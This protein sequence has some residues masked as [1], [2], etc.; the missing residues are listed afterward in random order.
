MPDNKNFHTWTL[1]EVFA[2][3][4][5]EVTKKVVD[6]NDSDSQIESDDYDSD[7]FLNPVSTWKSLFLRF[8]AKCERILPRS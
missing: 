6:Q 8:S 1:L 4:S 7:D 3:M 5:L 2:S